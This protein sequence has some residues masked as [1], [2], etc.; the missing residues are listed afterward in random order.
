V[1]TR[2]DLTLEGTC[3]TV[4]LRVENVGDRDAHN[5]EIV[6]R[7]VG[8][9]PTG[10][11]H[12]G[13]D[14][15]ST[16]D[17]PG[18]ECEVIIRAPHRFSAGTGTVIS[19]D[20]VPIL[21]ED[22]ILYQVGTSTSVSFDGVEGDHYEEEL[23]IPTWVVERPD[24]VDWH[25]VAAVDHAFSNADYLVVTYPPR[26]FWHYTDADVNEL[27]SLMASLGVERSGVL[28][29][30]DSYNRYVFQD[31]IEPGGDWSSR[32]I[33]DWTSDGYLVIVG[34]TEI[35]PSL[36]MYDRGIRDA[37]SSWAGGSVYPV[38]L[39][40]NYYAD[41]SGDDHLPELI[42]G[43]IIGDSPDQLMTPVQTS[44]LDQ[45]ERTDAL[46]ISGIGTGEDSFE[47]NADEV[48]DLL[49]DEFTVDQMY[50][51]DYAS[52]AQRLTQ[53]RNRAQDKDVFY[54][55][56]HGSINSWSHTVGTGNFPVNF[57]NSQPFAFGMACLTGNYEDVS[58]DDYC[59]A[60]AFL[61]NGAGVYIG[62][63][64]ASSRSRNNQAG[65]TFFEK[66]VNTS[67]SLGQAL[68]ETKR[69]LDVTDDR[70]RLW[71]MEYNLYG[72]PKYGASSA[73]SSSLASI[74]QETSQQPLPS[75]EITI[76]DYEV[77][78]RAGLDY[79]EIP[80]GQSLLVSD[81]PMVP[82]YVVSVD[83]AK[84][85]EVQ[86]VVLT[87]RSG[88]VTATGLNL[89]TVV[90]AQ[91]G[92]GSPKPETMAESTNS[93]WYPEEEYRWQ[94]V[95]NPDGSTT[96]RIMMYPFYYNPLTTDVKFYKDYRFDISYTV[97]SV[98]IANLTTDK[99]VYQQGDKVMVNIE[100]SNQGDSQDV[101]FN[102]L[103]KRYGSDEIVDGLLLRSLDDFEGEASFSPQ[104]D[105][106]GFDP[107]YYYVEVTL[108]DND[109]NVLDRETERFRLGISSG[110]ITSFAAT[111]QHFDIGD[112][113]NIS[114]V[115]SNSGTVDIPGTAVIRVQDEAA[116]KVQE[117]RHDITDLA[118]GNAISFDDV[119]DT[120]GA[121]EGT[122]SI[123]GYVLYDGMATDATTAVVS[124]EA[125]IYLPIILRNF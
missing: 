56:D 20:V 96:L 10:L 39:I 108:K 33:T 60:E 110:E 49:D 28:G 124:T 64:E 86:D 32:L 82:F 89:P 37:T 51:S 13:W 62:A 105:S 47:D 99:D 66:W 112:S 24:D 59:I 2:E 46:V 9:Q 61:D 115:F 72:D 111:P 45:F 90:T 54:F 22:D 31:L 17:S 102:A 42:V 23:S 106:S 119:W 88:L 14:L 53:F 87:E 83:Y 101:V 78:T 113:I 70:Y 41:I 75:L 30:L 40:D 98:E 7:L 50:G 103:T 118:P 68:K 3:L 123:V 81:K 77:T 6:D 34:E 121:E 15:T 55:R 26:L 8:F 29:Y 69:E 11:E 95:E 97:S 5:V 76:P 44:L 116:E 125:H 27:L 43:R 21:T 93:G 35:V 58:G 52:D 107:G 36:D 73:A 120:S 79:V 84:G 18:K 122:Y 57:G 67:T 16:F 12:S 91:G 19:Y 94:I 109:G 1:V 65:K 38:P 104:W 117:Y 114:L 48:A 25:L 4:A 63:T 80:G 74:A 92:D 100:L 85:Y 71:V